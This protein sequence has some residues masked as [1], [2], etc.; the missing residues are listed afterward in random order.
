MA[1]LKGGDPFV[2]GRGGEEALLL[3]ENGVPFEIVPGITSAISV[4]AYAGIP[5]THRGVAASFAV[6]TGHE[7]PTK[8]DSDINWPQLATAT[9]TL[10]FLMGVANLPKITAKLMEYGRSGDTPAAII[11][12]GTKTKQQVWTT[13]VADA[14]DMV[15]RENIKPPCIFIVGNV[16][17]LRKELSWFDN[18][19]IKPLFGK[20]IVVTRSRTQASMLTQRLDA[21]GADCMEVPVIKIVP[22]KDGYEALDK[23]I[24]RLSEFDF[25]I[26]T[27][28]NGVEHFFRRIEKAKL[29]SRHLAGLTICT[30]GNATAW[31]LAEFGIRADIVP[32]EFRAEGILAAL[33]GKVKAGD[34]VLLARAA[35]ARNIL[36]EELMKQGVDVTVV[37][38]YETVPD[39]TDGSELVQELEAHNIDVVTFA[40][41]S[42]VHNMMKLLGDNAVKLLES[43]KIAAIGA[44]TAG[45]CRE[46]GLKV[47]IQPERYS[48]VDMAKAIKEAF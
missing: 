3:Q 20:R 40:S 26:F 8:E 43:A 33:E 29:D 36:P 48:I 44:I 25:L 27:S 5:V 14:A 41:S 22:P 32:T 24:A 31:K 23:A 45:T 37:H 30:I 47:D 4:P 42:T 28:V 38:A 46:Y 11:R 19:A 7:D 2:F 1:R 13:T 9:D 17:N 35:E 6:V 15:K 16:V 12:W 34:K 39:T 21:M 10:V 18:T